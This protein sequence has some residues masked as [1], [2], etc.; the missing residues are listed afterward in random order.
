MT[1]ENKRAHSASVSA[2]KSP[3][4]RQ[5]LRK[6]PRRRYRLKSR[7]AAGVEKA[8]VQA[9]I[10]LRWWKK[11]FVWLGSRLSNTSLRRL[12]F[13]IVGWF[14]FAT[15]ALVL[16][17]ATAMDL[18]L[19]DKR[20]LALIS[21]GV[22][23]QTNGELRIGKIEFSVFSG[24]TLE[25]IE[26]IPPG[27]PIYGEAEHVLVAADRISAAWSFWQIFLGRIRLAHARVENPMVRIDSDLSGK[28]SLTEMLKWREQKFPKTEEIDE[29][30][31]EEKLNLRKLMPVSPAMIF[32]P[33]GISAQNVGVGN[34]VLVMRT[35]DPEKKV[36]VSS[37][38]AR[39]LGFD[40]GLNWWGRSSELA[41]HV[42]TEKGL[43]ISQST[44]DNA[45]VDMN[46]RLR[47]DANVDVLFE[48]KNLLRL[49]STQNVEFSRI[50]TPST[51]KEG[52]RFNAE[53]DVQV[54]PSLAA[55]EIERFSINASDAVVWD[56]K[57]SVGLPLG[58]LSLIRVSLEQKLGLRLGKAA[59]LLGAFAEGLEAQGEVNLESLRI[60]G[61]IEPDKLSDRRAP[62]L[63]SVSGMIFVEGVEI[64]WPPAG[65]SLLPVT[66]S[67]GLQAGQSLAGDG[68]QFE[69]SMDLDSSG[70]VAQQNL[71]KSQ[72]EVGPTRVSLTARA[73]WPQLILPIFKLTVESEYL[74]ARGQGIPEVSI[75]LYLDV[76][77][78]AWAD[79]RKAALSAQ[80]E[81]GDLFHLKVTGDCQEQCKKVR[82][83]GQ[84]QLSSLTDIYS[85]LMPVLARTD[86]VTKLPSGLA[87]E[88]EAD[89]NLRGSLPS[90]ET[91]NVK[92]L[93][94]EGDLKFDIG[95]ALTNFN[96]DL[97]VERVTVRDFDVRFN[98][99][100]DLTQ[101]KVFL[102]NKFARLEWAPPGNKQIGVERFSFDTNITNQ[103]NKEFN[104][105]DPLKSLKTNVST[106]IFS[107][108]LHLGG[109][110][111]KQLANLELRLDAQQTQ[112][113]EILLE[114]I[115]VKVPDLGADLV[116]DGQARL[117]EKL[118]LESFRVK[119]GLKVE[120]AGSGLIPGR[121]SAGG[122]VAIVTEAS[123]EDMEQIEIEGVGSFDRFSLSL[124][125]VLEKDAPRLILEGMSGQVPFRQ[126]I[127]LKSLRKEQ[128]SEPEGPMESKKSDTDVLA[129]EVDAWF[130]RNEDQILE[131][132]NM[133]ALMD[134]GSIR[135]FFPGR[136]PISIEKIEARN[137]ELSKM[138]FD[139][140]VRQNWF[141]VN[142]FIIGFLNGKIQ[143][144]TQ[145][146]FD[147]SPRTLRTN[148][149]LTRLDTRQ[150]IARFPELKSRAASWS[151]TSNPWL[152][153]TASLQW[154]LRS[155]D[156]SGGVEI[157][158]IGKEQLRMILYYV[159]PFDQNPNIRDIRRA[160]LV[161]E[162]RQVSI[163][164]KNGEIGMSVDVRLLAAPI[165]V[166]KLSRF[167]VAQIVNN[168]REQS[169]Q[170]ESEVL[171]AK[172]PEAESSAKVQSA[173]DSQDS[174]AR[175]NGEKSL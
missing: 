20:L 14:A 26:F 58:D 18:W 45:S 157:S 12:V 154:D 23:Q 96:V 170:G 47:V 68:S 108:A 129:R 35:L 131:N 67:A 101:Q 1:S 70:L 60:V 140:E 40:V 107:G 16:V 175:Q 156:M 146:A 123:S 19:T 75:P 57:G 88:I 120:Q 43:S 62:K 33:L 155:N 80:M 122:K 110:L 163:P 36:V 165:P 142:Q 132:T 143:G 41:L 6:L 15:T 149:H 172:V 4:E 169:R 102:G 112:G 168:F 34:A 78:E 128:K 27:E 106:Q 119:G 114:S 86:L 84:T 55:L 92:S 153:A 29:P 148:L 104:E 164:V 28:T 124:P 2:Q 83:N 161:G 31:S 159:D 141:A 10:A 152:D 116:A 53:I 39:G 22:R 64:K 81:L 130:E 73:L 151:L 56:L 97:P 135:P 166:P 66:G 85:V 8:M 79:L 37:Q 109:V 99:Q 74:T 93:L 46:E 95:A 125:G 76:D 63:P 100:G 117:A 7:V 3:D 162:V 98:A 126:S 94:G 136:Q 150:L 171:D 61:D 25:K 50:A 90:L 138:E 147:P 24:F 103:V 167:P 44:R 134:Y 11:P 32:M 77:A 9:T 52:V 139:V 87:G 51:T 89:F 82:A 137:L 145:V 54:D 115:A 48:L 91:L 133:M 17:G 127:A 30:K 71:R 59:D 111:P 144:S 160:L 173:V 105:N 158:S 69:V 21:S 72:I 65:L 13:Q 174:A 121:I 5:R 118:N 38:E 113:T 49:K 42:K